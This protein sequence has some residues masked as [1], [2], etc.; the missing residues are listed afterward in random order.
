MSI[1]VVVVA[2]QDGYL[3]YFQD[4]EE[5]EGY[6]SKEGGSQFHH[7]PS[8]LRQLSLDCVEAVRTEVL[9]ACGWLFFANVVTLYMIRAPHSSFDG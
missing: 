5:A 7:H 1:S 2:M 9:S 8:S 4:Q 6:R 3:S